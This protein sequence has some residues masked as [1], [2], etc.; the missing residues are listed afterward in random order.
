MVPQLQLH[1]ALG[2]AHLL[3]VTSLAVETEDDISMLLLTTWYELKL[4][5]SASLS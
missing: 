1:W 5:I 2:S 3:E 4:L